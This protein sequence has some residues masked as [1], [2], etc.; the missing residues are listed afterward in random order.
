MQKCEKFWRNWSNFGYKT[1]FSQNHAGTDF[2]FKNEARKL[3]FGLVLSLYGIF[4]SDVQIF[5]LFEFWEHE[6]GKNL[7]L[8]VRISYPSATKDTFNTSLTSLR[9][10]INGLLSLLDGL[11]GISKLN[12]SIDSNTLRGQYLVWKMKKTWNNWG[13]HMLEFNMS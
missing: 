4:E 10:H 12:M 6:I 5:Y 3:K 1:R 7:K 8:Q 13:F 11:E 9:E 2:F